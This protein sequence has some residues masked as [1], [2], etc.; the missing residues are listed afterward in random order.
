MRRRVAR[1]ASVWPGSTLA[2]LSACKAVACRILY[3]SKRCPYK[4]IDATSGDRVMS[5]F[6]I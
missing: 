2:Q 6:G 5:S 3:P 1:A 4:K